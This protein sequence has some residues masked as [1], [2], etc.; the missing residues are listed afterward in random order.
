MP[1]NVYRDLFVLVLSYSGRH[2]EDRRTACHGPISP[3]RFGLLVDRKIKGNQMLRP[4]P[5]CKD[6]KA[7]E[8]LL[9]VSKRGFVSTAARHPHRT[10]FRRCTLQLPDLKLVKPWHRYGRSAQNLAESAI[11]G[12]GWHASPQCFVPLKARLLV[13]GNRIVSS[14]RLTGAA[15]GGKDRVLRCHAANAGY[16]AGKRK[17]IF[18]QLNILEMSN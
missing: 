2:E 15:C 11:L 18:R 10:R 12:A 8:T 4:L 9:G 14:A 1:R 6:G 3:G 7:S 16:G 13:L 5:T 17:N